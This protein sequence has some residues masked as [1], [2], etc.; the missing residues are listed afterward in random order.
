[1]FGSTSQSPAHYTSSLIRSSFPRLVA[2]GMK[3]RKV[4]DY[5]LLLEDI[6]EWLWCD[7]QTIQ[8][9]SKYELCFDI[10]A[11]SSNSIDTL[12]GLVVGI[13]ITP[14]PRM[15]WWWKLLLAVLACM[16]ILF[17]SQSMY[18][19]NIVDTGGVF[20]NYIYHEPY[21][22]PTTPTDEF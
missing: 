19:C 20:E 7:Q 9:E 13:S 12:R 16:T 5:E 8:H 22:T 17:W 21:T 3:M 4:S 6:D 11:S 14:P 10:Y 15:L 2:R 18:F 1:M